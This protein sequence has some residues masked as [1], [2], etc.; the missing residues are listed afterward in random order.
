M[1]AHRVFRPEGRLYCEFE[2]F[3][4]LATGAGGPEVGAGLE[5]YFDGVGLGAHG[6]MTEAQDI[7]LTGWVGSDEPGESLVRSGRKV[8]TLDLRSMPDYEPPTTDSWPAP[9][10]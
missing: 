4:A 8:P 5:L 2:V 7:G 1:T 9:P 10:R 3:G 6:A